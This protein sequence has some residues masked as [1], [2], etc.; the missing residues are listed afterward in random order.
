MREMEIGTMGRTEKVVE[1]RREQILDSAMRAFALKGF[2]RATNKDIAK[3]AGITPGLIYHYFENKEAVLK[4]IIEERSPVRLMRSLSQEIQTLPPESLLRLLA[5]KVLQI[6]EGD[7]FVQVIRVLLP[8]AV[9]NQ[10]I[11]PLISNFL[12]D[13]ISSLSDYIATKTVHGELRQ[14]DSSLIAQ[15][16]IGCIMGFVLRR[17]ILRDPLALQYTQ[18]QIADA[19]VTTTLYGLLPR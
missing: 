16:F 12:K 4:A 18:Q 6:V 13:A 3:E 2:T 11:T 1:D 19:V 15:T 8:E 9:H 10:A 7:N 17:Q 14:G 5:Q